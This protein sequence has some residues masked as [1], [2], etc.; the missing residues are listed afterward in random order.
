MNLV[1][2]KLSNIPIEFEN[3][4]KTLPNTITFLE[5]ENIGK[6]DN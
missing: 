6:V 2:K 1:A 4:T 3:G 5:M